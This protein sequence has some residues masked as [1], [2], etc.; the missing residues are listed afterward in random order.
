MA[1]IQH[2]LAI[3]LLACLCSLCIT[4][5]KAG[6]PLFLKYFNPSVPIVRVDDLLSDDYFFALCESKPN[7]DTCPC[8][9]DGMTKYPSW[10]EF[11]TS[12]QKCIV[13]RRCN[14]LPQCCIDLCEGYQ[15]YSCGTENDCKTIDGTRRYF[16]CK[17]GQ[18][19]EQWNYRACKYDGQMDKFGTHCL[20]QKY[21]KSCSTLKD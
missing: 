19:C 5:V 16:N 14:N 6:E 10:W 12:T 13:K 7:A 4:C 20:C 3:L 9:S 11:L 8:T 15:S 2:S 17:A 18:V 21:N 1:R